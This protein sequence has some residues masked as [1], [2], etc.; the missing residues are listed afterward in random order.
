MHISS[1]PLHRPYNA[2][3]CTN[4]SI[5]TNRSVFIAKFKRHD[6]ES[7]ISPTQP[8]SLS[9]WQWHLATGLLQPETNSELCEYHIYMHYHL[10]T[11]HWANIQILISGQAARF[12]CPICN[13]IFLGAALHWAFT[14]HHITQHNITAF[15][16]TRALL[17]PDTGLRQ[18]PSILMATFVWCNAHTYIRQFTSIKRQGL[19][20][21]PDP[22][23][24]DRISHP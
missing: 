16:Y 8:L 12:S 13:F 9:L 18:L 3:Q 23:K 2:M 21:D 10:Q 24:R 22:D 5:P 17:L 4:S 11:A 20:P 1:A 15:W 6:V 19:G 7:C 14:S